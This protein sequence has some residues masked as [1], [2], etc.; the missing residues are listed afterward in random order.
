[1][2]PIDTGAIV[3]ALIFIVLLTVTWIVLG[4]RFGAVQ[5]ENHPVKTTNVYP[6]RPRTESPRAALIQSSRASDS[7]VSLHTT[8]KYESVSHHVISVEPTRETNY[9][10]RQVIHGRG[11]N[12]SRQHPQILSSDTVWV[13]HLSIRPQKRKMIDRP[14][15]PIHPSLAD[16]LRQLE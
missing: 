14:S 10:T 5:H 3:C 2:I 15:M 4:N 7:P 12:M 16:E 1:M 9:D 6:I 11:K 8:T 13:D